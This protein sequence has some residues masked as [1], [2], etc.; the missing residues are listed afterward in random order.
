MKIIIATDFFSESHEYQENLQAKYYRKAGHEVAVV[1]SLHQ[2][3]FDYYA[4]REVTGKSARS[5]SCN[6]I[7]II[8][9]PYQFNLFNRVKKFTGFS[10]ILSEWKPDVI[11]VHDIMPDLVLAAN[12][13]RRF[14]RTKLLVGYHADASN[15]GRSWFSLY[16]LHGVVRRLFL[17]L[18]MPQIRMI[19]PVVPAGIDFLRQ[20]YGVESKS[21]E[22][23]PLGVDSDQISQ[24]DPEKRYHLRGSLGIPVGATVIFTGGKLTP[25][26]RT[27]ML[28]EAVT[29]WKRPDV[30]VI[31]VGDSDRSHACYMDKLRS[32]A[33]LAPGTVHLVGWQTTEQIY[34]YMAASDLAV[35]PSSQSILWQQAIGVGLPLIVGD[36]GSQDPSYLNA[37]ANVIVLR[38]DELSADRLIAAMQTA[39]NPKIFERMVAG[40][41]ACA[42]SQLDWNRLVERS[43]GGYE[44]T[45][46]L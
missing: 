5:Y 13:C 30:H 35:F 24:I 31:I 44:S 32:L 27:D 1:T 22:L 34:A 23:L 43:L 10:D 42:A 3:A 39:S 14:P 6:G 41:K 21:M 36:I 37:N 29:R 20:Y 2:T 12:Y 28:I 40:A 8:R 4:D 11:F 46:H 38:R 18:A 17:K 33:A 9:L 15:S 16:L 45:P 26:K 19:F 25:E 7:E